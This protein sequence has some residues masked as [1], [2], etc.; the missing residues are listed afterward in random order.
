MS[1]STGGV[2]VEAS[3]TAANSAGAA[4]MQG[5]KRIL[6]NNCPAYRSDRAGQGHSDRKLKEEDSSALR[7]WTKF[8][9]YLYHSA[10][11]NAL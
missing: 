7:P 5:N 3:A 6:S 2:K 11:A 4:D 9:I 1:G 8:R 10:G